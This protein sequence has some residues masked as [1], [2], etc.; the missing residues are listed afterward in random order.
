VGGGRRG[1]R[2]ARHRRRG[3]AG[4]D[5]RRRA[6]G[7]HLQRL[8]HDQ[9]GRAAQADAEAACR[10]EVRR[11][12]VVW[13]QKRCYAV[14]AVESIGGA[15]IESDLP[16]PAC[17]TPVDTFPPAAPKDLKAIPTEG[18]ITLIW[19]PNGEKDLA[20]YIVLRG[21]E[22]AETL[23]PITPE[24]IADPSFKDE[25]KPGI[26]Y[27]Y[28]VR[29]MDKAGNAS[30]LSARAVETRA[31]RWERSASALGAQRSAS[32]LQ[33]ECSAMERIYRVVQDGETFYASDA[34]GELR[35]A[36]GDPFTTLTAGAAV[37]GGLAGVT[38]LAPVRPSKIVCVGL[39]YKDHAGEVGK[40]LPAEPL[41]FIKPPSA[42]IGPGE[43]IRRPPGVGR[44]DHEAELG[45]V[46]GRRAHPASRQRMPGTTS[47][48]SP[49]STT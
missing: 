46:V 42:V 7:D 20:G 32:R 24:P 28:A 19:E 1:A 22:P 31:D 39:N 29:A 10:R 40:A 17:E 5:D 15:T 45:I 2:S 12:R 36:S 11:H 34:D 8:R 25:V 38:L 14:A 13:G 44:V 30:A 49:A 35:R 6:A 21:V 3:A 16:P 47:S 23:T 43:P 26:A 33:L 41:L 48:A 4:A 9:P 27:V 18:A 37:R